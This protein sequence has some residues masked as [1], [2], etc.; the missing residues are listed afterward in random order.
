MHNLRQQIVSTN[1]A[2]DRERTEAK[3]HTHEVKR[4]RNEV[5]LMEAREWGLHQSAAVTYSDDT[6]LDRRH[7]H[8]HH[9]SS[10][11]V[12]VS[13]I[14]KEKEKER[15]KDKDTLGAETSG[16]VEELLKRA[17][18][19]KEQLS[20]REAQ[21]RRQNADVLLRGHSTSP[22]SAPQRSRSESVCTD[23]VGS[24]PHNS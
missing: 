23:S 11:D 9:M 22:Q 8:H 17:R 24:S 7:Q 19:A 6:T 15:E 2:R 13:G 18:R 10:E 3:G 5:R 12:Q 20:V 4:L 14:D 16:E 21:L 1:L